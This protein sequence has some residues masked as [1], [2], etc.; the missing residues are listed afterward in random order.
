MERRAASMVGIVDVHALYLG[1]VVKWGGLV[2]L[3][4]DMEHVCSVDVPTVDV[5][6]VFFHQFY[7]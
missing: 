3:S 7:D 6:A 5:R 1:E 4:R 2:A